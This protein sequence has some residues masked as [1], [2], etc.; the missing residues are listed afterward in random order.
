M[1]TFY[2]KNLSLLFFIFSV[3]IVFSQSH[4][5][6]WKKVDEAKDIKVYTSLEDNSDIKSVKIEAI[7][8]ADID[9]FVDQLNNVEEYPL[10]VYKC[11]EATTIDVKPDG[12]VYYYV[13]T[14]FP[15]PATDRDLVIK[16]TESV[17][18]NTGIFT[19]FSTAAPNLMDT[20]SNRIRIHKFESSWVIKPLS[21]N[22]LE[23]EYYGASDPEGY[24]PSWIINM[25]VTIGPI[26][27]MEKLKELV[28]HKTRLLAEKN[29]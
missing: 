18:S 19:T 10:W 5:V 6:D 29:K 26:N 20:K 25:G 24:I 11:S 3:S 16:S 21:E 13:N 1:Y 23:V 15:F 27:T 12:T 4:T 2:S 14:D 17:D 8:Y 7:V 9:I 28:E 22:M